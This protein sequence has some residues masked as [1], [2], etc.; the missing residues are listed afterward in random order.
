MREANLPAEAPQ[1]G[2]QARVPAPDGDPGRSGH[3]EG[4]APEGSPASFGLIGSVTDRATFAGL[5][6]APRAR[7]G[8]IGVSFVARPG[9]RSR[10]AFS[11]GKRAGGAVRRNR[12]R[13]RLRAAVAE[14][15]PTLAPGAYLV[16]AGPEAATIPFPQLT[17]MVSAAAQRVTAEVEQ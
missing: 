9:E 16:S 14:L 11:V 2:P 15:G 13:R 5:R 3:P 17:A 12:I 10:V 4:P 1:A 8:P 7:V 6:A